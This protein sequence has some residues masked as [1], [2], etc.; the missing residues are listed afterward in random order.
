[1]IT[2][3]QLGPSEYWL[4]CSICNK[5]NLSQFR[6]YIKEKETEESV[7]PCFC[8]ICKEKIESGEIKYEIQ[9]S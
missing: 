4:F 3:I 9:E 7:G 5:T 6:Y 1:M 2:F 8:R